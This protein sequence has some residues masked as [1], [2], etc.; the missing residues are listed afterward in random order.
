M[1]ASHALHSSTLHVPSSI[2]SAD[3]CLTCPLP[4]CDESSRRCALKVA[5]RERH[6]AR[7]QGA[8]LPDGAKAAYNAYLRHREVEREADRSEQS[9]SAENPPSAKDLHALATLSPAQ[10]TIVRRLGAAWPHAAPRAELV[11]LVWPGRTQRPRSP[12]NALAVQ[13]SVARTRIESRGWTIETRYARQ[14][15]AL[16]FCLAPIEAAP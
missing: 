7:Q 6:A 12:E 8:T 3:P 1:T 15:A 14:G 2:K 16:S 4:D 9:G 5:A 10:Q 11:D 13:I